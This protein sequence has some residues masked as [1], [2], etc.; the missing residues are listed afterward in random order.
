MS[1]PADYDPNWWRAAKALSL[2]RRERQAEAVAAALAGDSFLIVTEG[3]VTEVCYFEQLRAALQLSAVKVVV[4][5]GD[6]SE[7]RHVIETAARLAQEQRY[8]A[9]RGQLA[10][11]EPSSYDQVWAVLDTDVSERHNRW[12]DILNL[13]AQRGVRLASSTPCFEYWLLLHLAHTTAPLANGAVAKAKLVGELGDYSTNAA[14]CEAAIRKI[15]PSW[16][17]AT[18]RAEQVR[19]Y[20]LDACTASPANPSTEV[21]RLTMALNYSA[22]VHARKIRPSVN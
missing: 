12:P 16:P 22:P 9:A 5:P 2:E 10:M 1:D 8:R 18:K 13:A 4:E 3:V 17:T 15:L 19:Q 21:D 6:D 14:V 11:D 20:H 7:A